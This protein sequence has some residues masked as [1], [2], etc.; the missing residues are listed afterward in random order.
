MVIRNGQVYQLPMGSHMYGGTAPAY[1]W[2]DIMQ[3]AIKKGLGSKVPDI[4][5]PTEPE[6]KEEE[7]S[8]DSET[9]VKVIPPEGDQEPPNG[10][11]G[12]D[13]APVTVPDPSDGATTGGDGTSPTVNPAGAR[14]DPPTSHRDPPRKH[15]D[16]DRTVQVDICA[17]SGMRATIYCPETV[18]RT[19]RKGQE[20]KKRCTIHGG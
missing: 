16:E 2:R 18:T 19:F 4:E 17:E 12:G 5:A 9:R 3:Y 7:P 15:N 10:T 6:P 14:P 11:T 1:F 8:H 20:P 13:G